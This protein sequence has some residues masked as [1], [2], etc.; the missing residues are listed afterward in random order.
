MR[1]RC[2]FFFFSF[3]SSTHENK[4]YC[5]RLTAHGEIPKASISLRGRASRQLA[6]G[7]I[8]AEQKRNYVVH[9]S[10]ISEHRF[11]YGRTEDNTCAAY[12][13]ILT[14][15]FPSPSM[16]EARISCAAQRVVIRPSHVTNEQE[17]RRTRLGRGICRAF[18]PH[19]EA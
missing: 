3:L 7:E 17:A 16:H 12:R 10:R 9:G 18:S 5:S 19:L 4:I 14:R 13:S 15:L 8:S 1:L 2:P 6:D 11:D